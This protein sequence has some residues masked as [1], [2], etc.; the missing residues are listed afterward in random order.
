MSIR[1]FSYFRIFPTFSIRTF[2][3]F[4]PSL[5]ILFLLIYILFLIYLRLCRR[6]GEAVFLFGKKRVR[7]FD[8]LRGTE[9]EVVL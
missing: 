2:R 9:A 7:I 4:Y 5:I 8:F 6:R 3:H 1:K